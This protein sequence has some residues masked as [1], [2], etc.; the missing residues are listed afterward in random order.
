MAALRAV[1]TDFQSR[2]FTEHALDVEQVSHA[3]GGRQ[4]TV[5]APGKAHRQSNRKRSRIDEIGVSESWLSI[6]CRRHLP[7]SAS[8]SPVEIEDGV[9]AFLREEDSETGT[10]GPF[11]RRAP[12][13]PEPRGEVVVIGVDHA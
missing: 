11:I 12:G 13:N 10:D 8:E 1:V 7:G 2:R 5:R 6:G 9:L 4:Y 3:V